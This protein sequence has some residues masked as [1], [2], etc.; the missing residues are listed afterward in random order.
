MDE[1]PGVDEAL[2]MPRADVVLSVGAI[3]PRKN[4]LGLVRAARELP[5]RVEVVGQR[6]HPRDAYAR[7]VLEEAPENVVFIGPLPR[8]Q[9]LR[10]LGQARVHV[11][12]G[13]VETPGLASL[14]AAALGTPV[15]VADTSPVREYFLDDACYADP[16][17]VPSLLAALRG[18][19]DRPPNRELAERVR[20]CYDWPVALAPLVVAVHEVAGATRRTPSAGLPGT[21]TKP[22][23]S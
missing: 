21:R 23:A 17:S 20:R 14:E 13:F 9:V 6:P 8:E 2:S 16:H 19:W 1:L 15:V 4:T 11:Q 10:R 3:S 12:P 22:E 5:W 18:A 7:R